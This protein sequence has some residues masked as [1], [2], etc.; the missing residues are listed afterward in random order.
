LERGR[1]IERGTHAT[2]L[3]R[4][5]KYAQL[6]EHSFL[7]K[8]AEELEAVTEPAIALTGRI[9]L[10]ACVSKLRKLALRRKPD[11]IMR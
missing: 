1:I 9:L 6:W 11:Q 7:E 10:R 8:P 3:E 4:G 2:L 5:E